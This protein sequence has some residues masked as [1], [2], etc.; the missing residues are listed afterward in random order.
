MKAE[1]DGEAG[2]A[3]KR[4]QKVE[5]ERGASAIGRLSGFVETR[6]RRVMDAFR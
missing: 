3:M 1:H 2:A 6:E 4:G 5:L